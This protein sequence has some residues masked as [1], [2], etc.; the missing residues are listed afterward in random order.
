MMQ[1]FDLY[2]MICNPFQYADLVQKNLIWKYLGLGCLLCFMLAS[3]NLWIVAVAL[4]WFRDGKTFMIYYRTY[5][6]IANNIDKYTIGKTIMI[7]IAYAVVI[8][9]MSWTTK[10]ALEESTKMV[11]SK[12]KTNLHRRLLYFSLLP[13]FLN[14]VFSIPEA[15]TELNQRRETK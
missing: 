7:K 3:D 15:I 2:T 8:G 14:V 11:G 5:N 13:L 6:E 10:K 12:S 1:S 9:K 4:Y